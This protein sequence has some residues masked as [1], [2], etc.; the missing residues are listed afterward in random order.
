MSQRK[1]ISKFI[2]N[3]TAKANHRNNKTK[4]PFGSL[5]PF[6]VEFEPIVI[7]SPS[8]RSRI[9]FAKDLTARDSSADLRMTEKA[10]FQV[11]MV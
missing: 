8:L 4:A 11:K 7:L 3:L 10:H 6:P 9:N 2:N 1:M 5:I